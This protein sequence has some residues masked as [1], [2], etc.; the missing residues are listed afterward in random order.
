MK[1]STYPFI[2]LTVMLL[3]GCVT[4]TDGVAPARPATN[5]E[6]AEANLALGVG[7][8][9]QE[10]PDLA[11]EA[12]V[13]AIDFQPRLADAHSAIALAYDQTGEAE[14]AEEHHR[15]AAQLE[16]ANPSVQNS[17][18]VFLCRQNR[19]TDARPYFQRAI[20]NAGSSSPVRT[21][22][23]AATCARESGDLESA[24]GFYRAVLDIEIANAAA[25]R[26]MIELSVRA[27][28]YQSGRAFWQRLDQSTTV[29]S[30]DL[31]F[32]YV[33]ERELEADRAAQECAAR[34]QREF[35]QSAALRQLR[36]LESDGR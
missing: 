10:R 17:Y 9:Q 5:Q 3:A 33:I 27:N 13:R 14:L 7:Y 1:F 32:C 18:A 19:W 6:Q 4:V 20:S 8:L 23:N 22:V 11:I 26:G 31:L 30:Q 25:L 28:N 16:P 21:M 35:P 29:E 15:R 2:S 36:L 12:L 24:E 34:L